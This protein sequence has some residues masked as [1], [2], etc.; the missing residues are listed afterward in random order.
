MAE[1]REKRSDRNGQPGQDGDSVNLLVLVQHDDLVGCR[2]DSNRPCGGIDVPDES[3][4][5]LQVFQELAVHPMITSIEVGVSEL[6]SR[7]FSR[8][9]QVDSRQARPPGPSPARCS[10][11]RRAT[12]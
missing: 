7:E 10:S 3:N 6:S 4:A 8:N 1:S 5:N 2:E 11:Q 9:D 12:R